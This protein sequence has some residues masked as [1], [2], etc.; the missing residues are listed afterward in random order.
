MSEYT[1]ECQAANR[2]A[3]QLRG[4][5]VPKRQAVPK[6]KARKTRAPVTGI[7]GKGAW[8]RVAKQAKLAEV[9]AYCHEF[10]EANDQLPPQ[11][12]V[13]KRFGVLELTGRDYMLALGNAGHLERN[14][15]GKWRFARKAAA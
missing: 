11:A 8:L 12:A 2:I 4:E 7:A 14:E 3:A 15:V 6:K 10:F 5:P 9:L 13:A 1:A